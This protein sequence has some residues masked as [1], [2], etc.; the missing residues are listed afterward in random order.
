MTG[1]IR[2]CNRI[3]GAPGFILNFLILCILIVFVLRY[4]S[5]VHD[6]MHELP[7]NVKQTLEL[8]SFKNVDSVTFPAGIYRRNHQLFTSASGQWSR[9]DGASD[10]WTSAEDEAATRIQLWLMSFNLVSKF[11]GLQGVKITSRTQK[12][13]RV[14]LISELKI[15]CNRRLFAKMRD[16]S[17]VKTTVIHIVEEAIHIAVKN[18]F[19]ALAEKN[20]LLRT[21]DS[22]D[23]EL[24]K[25]SSDGSS[26]RS[27]V[28]SL[29]R[30]M[31]GGMKSNNTAV[32][33]SSLSRPSDEGV[34]LEDVDSRD[35]DSNESEN[36][37]TDSGIGAIGAA[38]MDTV[39]SQTNASSVSSNPNSG[40]NFA[41]RMFQFVKG[42]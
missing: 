30:A 35:N 5:Y 40:N 15:R 24:R 16:Y 9:R 42:K 28:K 21:E 22:T 2:Y 18:N 14:F 29:T 12:V 10:N 32:A 38:M 7:I 3:P 33:A 20:R 1:P 34:S 4:I 11:N 23:Y 26:G 36:D 27:L 19:L 13:F 37:E 41:S 31:A 17:V 25:S 6:H 8:M 39:L